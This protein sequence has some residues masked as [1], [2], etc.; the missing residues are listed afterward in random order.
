M[1]FVIVKII[2]VFHCS[3]CVLQD[4]CNLLYCFQ[5]NPNWLIPSCAMLKAIHPRIASFPRLSPPPDNFLF[6]IGVRRRDWTSL[7]YDSFLGL[8]LRPVACILNS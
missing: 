4:F 6:F 1:L 5:C 3:V 2:V 7:R 8:G